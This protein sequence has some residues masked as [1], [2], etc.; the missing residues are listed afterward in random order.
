MSGDQM[1]RAGLRALSK[2]HRKPVLNEKQLRRS[3]AEMAA[4]HLPFAY[5]RL[6]VD[7]KLEVK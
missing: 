5:I 4:Q 3:I 7:E 2:I 1:N 6:I